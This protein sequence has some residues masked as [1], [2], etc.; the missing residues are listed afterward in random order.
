[1]GIEVI[2]DLI[3]RELDRRFR[4]TSHEK[5][6]AITAYDPQTYSIKMQ[7]KPGNQITGWIPMLSHFIGNACGFLFGPSIGDQVSASFLGGDLESGTIVGRHFDDNNPPPQ[8]QSGEALLQIKNGNK[9]YF[10]QDG[11]VLVHHNTGAEMKLHPNGD[12]HI[13]PAS[14]NTLYLGGDGSIGSYDYVVTLSGPSI[15][16][17][18]RIS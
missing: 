10:M 3:H 13:M 4:G 17:K 11:S 9:L 2:L 7:I 12:A 5:K 6:G 14:K 1:V 16:T 18:A 8:V 15:N